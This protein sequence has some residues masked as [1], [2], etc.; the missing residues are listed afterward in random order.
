[1]SQL[2][3]FYRG[4]ATD[5][6]GRRLDD[7]WAWGD[8]RW[9]E[10]HDFIQWLFP[11]PEPSAFNPDAPLLSPE[12]V[13]AFRA[14]AALQARLRRSFDRFIAFVGLS[15]TETGQVVEAPNFTSRLADA[16]AFRNHNWLRISRVLRCLS[17]LGLAAE[18]RSFFAWLEDTF[19]RKRFPIGPDTFRYWEQ[20][21]QA[22]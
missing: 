1:M 11:L 9:E 16:W 3:D 12:D 7:I 14:D 20:A 19:R 15:R 21:V 10:V 13:A 18:A 4:G 6:E 5:T 8:D 2:L 22:A 17:L